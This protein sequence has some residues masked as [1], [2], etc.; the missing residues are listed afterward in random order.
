M[1]TIF[2]LGAPLALAACAK[3]P[4]LVSADVLAPA[5]NESAQIR[6]IHGPALLGE[7]NTRSV[8]GPD[9]WRKLND[10]QSPAKEGS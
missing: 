8:A 6:H 1:K 7:F 2:I 9:D 10:Q 4:E 3:A 5:S